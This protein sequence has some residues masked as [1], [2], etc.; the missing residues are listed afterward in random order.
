LVWWVIRNVLALV[1]IA[2]FAACRATVAG[3]TGAVKVIV[4]LSKGIVNAV[5]VR[6]F[7]S[8][9]ALV[10]VAAGI[11]ANALLVPD[12]V[13]A[14]PAFWLIEM[15]VPE[16]TS[17]GWI[18]EMDPAFVWYSTWDFLRLDLVDWTV[19]PLEIEAVH[20][21]VVSEVLVKQARVKP[22]VPEGG[23]VQPKPSNRRIR[24]TPKTQIVNAPL[25]RSDRIA[26]RTERLA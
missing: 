5:G 26:K 22:N 4:C 6:D 19:L 16:A 10:P 18:P 24:P 25:R 12:T 11:E 15:S 23:L 8:V 3:A 14:A 21:T 2:L 9:V 1:C 20:A 7:G 17:L 13:E